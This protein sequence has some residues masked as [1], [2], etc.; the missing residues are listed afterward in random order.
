MKLYSKFIKNIIDFSASCLGLLILYPIL[1]IISILIV[2]DS[3]FPF[4]YCQKRVGKNNKD[5]SLFK[6]RTMIN[7][8]DKSGLLTIGGK[9]SRVTRIG[10]YL[11]KFKLD[12]LLQLINIINGTM[13]I[14]GPRPEVRKYVDL[15]TNEQLK[16]LHVKPGLT[17]FASIEY[18]DENEILSKS[19]NPEE[20]YINEIMPHKLS[21]NLIYIN[22]ISFLTDFKIII[23]TFLKIINRK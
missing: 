9:D 8:A 14:V 7:N 6:F 22:Q 15:Y 18:F 12:E 10:Y 13:S 23:S 5:F 21:L 2:F 20:I 3:G 19:S 11:R 16:V 4:Y 1:F 17:D